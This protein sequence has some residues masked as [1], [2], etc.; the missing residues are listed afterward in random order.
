MASVPV[1]LGRNRTHEIE[2]PGSV[3]VSGSFSVEITNHGAPAHMH[4]NLDDDL[5]QVATLA[6]GNHYVKQDTTRNVFVETDDAPKPVTGRLKIVTG[7][8]A[9]TKYVTVT[10]EPGPDGKP[11]VEVDES[12]GK[13]NAGGRSGSSPEF[14][15]LRER[16]E[17]VVP[18]GPQLALGAV[19]AGAVLLAIIVGVTIGSTAVLVGTGVVVGAAIAAFLLARD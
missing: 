4:L 13:P 8:G 6:A 3:T 7:Y 14:V 18:D 17:E 12:L 2:A 5:S 1:D 16:T 11:P 15:P 19:V 9:E 10:V